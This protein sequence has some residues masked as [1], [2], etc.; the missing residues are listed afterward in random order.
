[1]QCARRA[2]GHGR[3]RT[4]D[5]S[6]VANQSH[7]YN[8]NKHGNRGAQCGAHASGCWRKFRNK[9]LPPRTNMQDA[10]GARR[11]DF[12][13]VAGH[14]NIMTWMRADV[15]VCLWEML[16]MSKQGNH[17]QT[18]AAPL[19]LPKP[20]FRQALIV[21]ARSVG[22]T[23]QIVVYIFHFSRRAWRSKFSGALNCVVPRWRPHTVT[24]ALT[25]G[26]T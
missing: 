11:D 5:E 14:V 4:H 24:I 18:T 19:T 13:G 8:S 22:N 23:A 2:F 6:W 25:S 10:F 1:M 9:H 7:Q 21:R 16:L 12:W 17:L 20:K 15:Q 26:P 3:D